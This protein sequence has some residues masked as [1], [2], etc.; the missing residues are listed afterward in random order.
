MR[1]ILAVAT[2]VF[3]VSAL[4]ALAQEDASQRKQRT[5]I[6][7]LECDISGG[8]GFILGSSKDMTCVFAPSDGRPPQQFVGQVNRFGLDVGATGATKLQWLV[9]APTGAEMPAAELEG[10]YVGVGVEA[11]AG[12]G[13]GANVLIGGS[14]DS[15]ALQPISIQGQAGLNVAA[16]ITEF[17]LRA[18]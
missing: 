18:V 7:M 2:A 9:M 1:K 13:L 14:M 8:I 5:E 4:P 17:E 16:G 6:G 15:F 11:T 10:D 3:A 12:L